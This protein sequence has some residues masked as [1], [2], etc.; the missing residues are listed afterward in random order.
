MLQV[1]E[2]TE[3]QASGG[4][5]APG[6]QILGPR[7]WVVFLGR[8]AE[9]VLTAQ[10]PVHLVVAP[11]VSCQALDQATRSGRVSTRS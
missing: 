2:C 8:M 3:V 5:A 6:K 4:E 10:T 11:H 7:R 1:L 9:T